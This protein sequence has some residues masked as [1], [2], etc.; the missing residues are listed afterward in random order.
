LK[1]FAKLEEEKIKPENKRD[2]LFKWLSGRWSDLTSVQV[3]VYVQGTVQLTICRASAL[4]A[5]QVT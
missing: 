2:R 4:A 1:K 5:I 3:I